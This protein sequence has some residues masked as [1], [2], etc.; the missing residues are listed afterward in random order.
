MRMIKA[1]AVFLAFVMLFL[2][3]PVTAADTKDVN[4]HYIEQTNNYINGGLDS[5]AYG[6]YLYSY[7]EFRDKLSESELYIACSLLADATVDVNF[8]PE[9]EDY[10][11]TISNMIAISESENPN[12]ISAQKELDHLKGGGDYVMDA[13]SLCVDAYSLTSEFVDDDTVKLLSDVISGVDDVCD[14]AESA[15]KLI[16][17]IE[18]ATEQYARYDVI[19]QDIEKNSTGDLN[20]AAAL[21]RKHM[22]SLYNYALSQY[23][24]YA[25][26]GICDIGE[27]IFDF[28]TEDFINSLPKEDREVFEMYDNFNI[29]KDAFELGAEGSLFLGNV[30]L[31]TEDMAKRIREIIAVSELNDVLEAAALKDKE[32]FLLAYEDGEATEDLC[33]KYLSTVDYIF[34]NRRRGEYC[35]YSL[36]KNDLGLI[37]FFADDKELDGWY[38][39]LLRFLSE[40]ELWVDKVSYDPECLEIH[41]Y[42]VFSGVADTWEEAEAYCRSLGGHLVTIGGYE[43]NMH[44]Y[45]LMKEA[46]YESAYIG[47]Y[48]TS[49]GAWRWCNGETVIYTNWG[50]SEPTNEG[51]DEDYGMFY[52]KFTD[53]SWNDGDFDNTVNG[54]KAFICEWDE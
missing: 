23:C 4:I 51:G 30:I 14:S 20:K 27:T 9:I 17:N 43:E 47:L 21:M 39:K 26:Q 6:D 48:E 36:M 25:E 5:A 40:R 29:L 42:E 38:E 10:I 37:S 12:D 44:V 34:S 18:T 13:I 24:E 33:D 16:S 8:D 2:S 15:V 52:F 53:G 54:G 11:E 45:N 41:R 22:N 49:A 31:N 50:G 7:E 32:S 19:L 46:G 1:L 3:F 35:F 28:G